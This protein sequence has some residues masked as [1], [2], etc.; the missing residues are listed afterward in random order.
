MYLRVFV[1]ACSEICRGVKQLRLRLNRPENDG[2]H[3]GVLR[4]L[5]RMP[6]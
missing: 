2:G 3:D 6:A 1:G 5:V 4:I